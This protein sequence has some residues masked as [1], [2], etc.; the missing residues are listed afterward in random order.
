MNICLN[1]ISDEFEMGSSQVKTRSLGQ[2]LEKP[3]ARFRVHIF[4]L[5]LMKLHQNVCLDEILGLLENES[6]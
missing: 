2:I 1:E 3:S 5:I 4:S 6:C